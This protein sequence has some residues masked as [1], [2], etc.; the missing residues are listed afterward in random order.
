MISTHATANLSK[1]RRPKLYIVIR[2]NILWNAKVKKN[3]VL[4]VTVVAL[5]F[6]ITGNISS[7]FRRLNQCGCVPRGQKAHT[8]CKA[9][10]SH[11]VWPPMHVARV[12]APYL[13]CDR[14]TW[15]K[16]MK[17]L[18]EYARRN[19]GIGWREQA[20]EQN[21]LTICFAPNCLNLWI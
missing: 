6:L 7:E 8:R 20:D 12:Y 9:H 4:A 11:V 13:Q 19:N 5:G 2:D 16:H 21:V 18:L 17:I 3:R 14:Q 1:R 10:I 15:I